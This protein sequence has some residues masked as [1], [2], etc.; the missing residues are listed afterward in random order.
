[1]QLPV[2]KAVARMF[3]YRKLEKQE[4]FFAQ[5]V[6]FL[7]FYTLGLLDE[8]WAHVLLSRFALS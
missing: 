8:S 5:D 7:L 4:M 1:M 3:N 6:Q 2:N